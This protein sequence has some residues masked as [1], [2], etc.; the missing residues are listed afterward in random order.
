MSVA[1]QQHF[2]AVFGGELDPLANGS[3]TE[4]WQCGIRGLFNTDTPSVDAWL[5]SVGPTVGG[6]F[7][8]S[9]VAMHP[10]SRMS[11]M[12]CNAIGTN[13]KYSDP[14]HPH[15]WFASSPYVGTGTAT[16]SPFLALCYSWTTSRLRGVGSHGRV[17]VPVGMPN[18]PSGSD[19]ISSSQQGTAVTA[20]KTL[21]TRVHTTVG[22]DTFNPAILSNKDASATLITGVRI[23]QVIDVQRRRKNR[24]PE[25]Y[26]GAAWP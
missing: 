23:G 11:W 24:V 13:G 19:I 15:T 26:I 25:A 1:Y 8:D 16:Y 21:L 2:Y 6:W 10:K 9:S 5:A 22:T 7:A 12:K 20:A 18:T 14:S 3:W 17:Y 4:V